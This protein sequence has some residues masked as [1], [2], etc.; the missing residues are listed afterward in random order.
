MTQTSEK[1]N[2]VPSIY[3]TYLQKRR[4]GENKGQSSSLQSL[5]SRGGSILEHVSEHVRETK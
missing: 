1:A 5:E 4:M 2:V 3:Y